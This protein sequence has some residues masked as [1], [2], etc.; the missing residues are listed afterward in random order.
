[1]KRNPHQ[2]TVCTMLKGPGTPRLSQGN[3]TIFSVG[4][5]T[6]LKNVSTRL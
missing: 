5:G 1:M 3:R 4:D 2:E 6:E